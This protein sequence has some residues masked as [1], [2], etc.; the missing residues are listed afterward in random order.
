LS[1]KDIALSNEILRGVVGSTA[2]GTAVSGQDDRDEMGIFIEPM[3]NVIG[4]NAIP[5]YIQRDQLEGIRSQPGDLDLTLY[6]ARKYVALAAHGNPS[7]LLLMYLPEFIKSGSLGDYLVANRHLF[8]SKE[9]GKRFLGYL[10][11]QKMKLK[12]EKAHT[13]NRPELIEKYGFDTKF[14]MHAARLGLQG[15]EYL[16]TGTISLPIREPDLTLC[17]EIRTGK[18]TFG[19]ALSLIDAVEADLRAEINKCDLQIDM[20]AIDKLLIYLHLNHWE[21][22]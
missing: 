17:R 10:V 9:A 12:G 6:S 4:L 22:T 8:V 16:S 13:V 21:K 2:H 20:K 15:I 11:A 5:H 1:P 19:Q 3:E 18:Y 7:V 14:A